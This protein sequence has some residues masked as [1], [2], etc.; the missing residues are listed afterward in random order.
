MAKFQ[1]SV[2]VGA[3]ADDDIMGLMRRRADAKQEVDLELE[4]VD[5]LLEVSPEDANKVASRVDISIKRVES[6]IKIFQ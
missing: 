5:P 2:C 1:D 3:H 6:F 4:F